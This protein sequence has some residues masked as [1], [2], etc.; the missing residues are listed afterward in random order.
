MVRM[1]KRDK[2]ATLLYA[3]N[4]GHTRKYEEQK[5][6]GFSMTKSPFNGGSFI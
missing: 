3:D 5:L 2:Y 6:G 4:G 1:R